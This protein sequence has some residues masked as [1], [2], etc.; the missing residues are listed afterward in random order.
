M[1]RM[2]KTALIA[3]GLYLVTFIT[4]I[5]ALALKAP[6]RD[7]VDFILGAGSSTGVVWA[8]FLEVVLALACIGTAVALFPVAKRHSEAA[9]VGFVAARV[10]EAVIIVIGVVSLFSVVTLRQDL[11][12]AAGTD[13]ASLVTTGRSLVALHD[14]TFLL[15]PGLIPGV[16][17]LFLGYVMYRSRLVP[18][19]IPLMGLIGAPMLLASATATM[20]GIYDQVSTWSAVATLPVGLWEL[21][22]GVWL[23]VKGFTPS[24]ITDESTD[25]GVASAYQSVAA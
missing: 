12:G 23:V 2:R 24:S 13:A 25:A 14:W 20:F 6:V 15:G 1:D 17:A 11:A 21:S 4:S 16:N 5:P 8:S 18:R 9:A 3:G 7:N 10:L 19:V 22:L